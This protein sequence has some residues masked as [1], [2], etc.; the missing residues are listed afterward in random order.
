MQ[1][2]IKYII[3][4]LIIG[5]VGYNAVYFKKLSE[6]EAEAKSFDAPSY[7]KNLI[8]H[9]LQPILDSAITLD[10]LLTELSTSPAPLFKKHGRSLTIGS[11]KFF[12]VK[13][14]GHVTA[15]DDSGVTV[16]TD[17]NNE[18]KIATEYIFGNGIRDASGLVNLNDFT[19][20]TDLS[21]ISSEINKIIR[22]T[23]VPPFR[24]SV[25]N[26]DLVAFTGAI[27]LNQAHLDFKNAELLP[28]SLKI[29]L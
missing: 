29:I 25:K 7:A 9:K 17:Q 27:E 23:V 3:W 19:N 16:K 24:A 6:M 14:T 10:F 21:N 2:S 26:G 18:V 12:M 4:L 11:S 13:G 15:I 20:T 1:K 28:V 22:K 8:D 5:L